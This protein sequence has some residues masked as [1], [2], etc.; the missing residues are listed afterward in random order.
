MGSNGKFGVTIAG[1]FIFTP[2]QTDGAYIHAW[3][4]MIHDI[5]AWE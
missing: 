5:R 1:H 4:L 2:T 3:N